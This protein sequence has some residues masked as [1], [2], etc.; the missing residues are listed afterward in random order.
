MR[1]AVAAELN[2]GHG[3]VVLAVSGGVD[4]M[5]L[6]DAAASSVDR[7]R[8]I[9]ATFDHGTGQFARDAVDLVEERCR[10][11]GVECVVGRASD[12]LAGEA[13]FRA[14]RWT[15]LRDVADARSAPIATAHTEDDQLETVLMRIMRDAGARG[16]AGLY[17]PSSVLRPL[18]GVRRA[19]IADY[20][21]TRRLRWIED[22]TNASPAYFRNRLRN[23]L[24]P[25]LRS[26][27][28]TIDATLLGVAR[29][30]AEHRAD[31]ESVCAE[32]S[33]VQLL[34]SGGIRA[35]IEAFGDASVARLL[36]P[37]VA[38]RIGAVLDRRGIERLAS[39][40]SGGRVGG[41]VQLSGGW[42]VTRGRHSMVLAR[43]TDAD[44]EAT[45][46]PFALSDGTCFGAWSFRTAPSAAARDAW[47]AWLPA[48][49]PLSV[50][51][52]LP[53]D[54]LQEQTGGSRRRVKHLLTNAGVTGHERAGWPVVLAGDD[55]VWIP[56]VRR[57]DAATARSGRPGLAFVCEYHNR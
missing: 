16:L 15:F 55:I 9:V 1:R 7:S 43:G 18:V 46:E 28:P 14:A 41:R 2:A 4:S 10:E 54:A 19:T 47:S 33:G 51:R 56:G 50:R 45:A 52:W 49:V 36:W 38:A 21:R 25:A 22:P 29:A 34:A 23:D 11:L 17:A 30:A 48:D 57:T 35:P 44:G 53:G 24:L 27:D 39:F 32:I 12:R 8:L 37:A 40:A 13:A 26:V 5:V 6:L 20:A 42:Q 31:V 3:R